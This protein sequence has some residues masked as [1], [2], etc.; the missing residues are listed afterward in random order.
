MRVG[1]LLLIRQAL[2]EGFQDAQ[3]RLDK[4]SEE[5]SR[6]TL[7]FILNARVVVN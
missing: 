3:E 1:Q 7:G 4:D 6:R 2:K 5:S